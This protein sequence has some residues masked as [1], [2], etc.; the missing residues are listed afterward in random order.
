LKDELLL[1]NA[2]F[3]GFLNKREAL[4]F[5]NLLY[6]S[7]GSKY[8]IEQ[9]FRGFYGVDPDVRFPKDNIF[10][11]GPR[12]DYD[13]DSSNS[14]SEQVTQAASFIGSES[15]K[16]LTDDKRY[17]ILSVL[18]R[19]G[20]PIGEWRDVYKLFAHPA[21]MYLASELVLTAANE[22]G[23]PII[24]DE[25]GAPVLEFVGT[26]AT[27]TMDLQGNTDLTLIV[28]DDYT[29]SNLYRQT[30]KQSIEQLQNITLQE[31][32]TGTDNYQDLLSPNSISF[33]ESD[34]GSTIRDYSTFGDTYYDSADGAVAGVITFDQHKYDTIYD[35]SF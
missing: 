22:I 26:A 8:A 5:S 35:S 2:Y 6:R 25:A 24:Q 29:D 28:R 34:G 13:Q 30:A 12:V 15:E 20:L 16:F 18:I 31:L 17:Q 10:I 3:E 19:T 11:V 27:A 14:A 1:G 23:I 7:K 32:Q 21:G 4:K 33:D 9:F